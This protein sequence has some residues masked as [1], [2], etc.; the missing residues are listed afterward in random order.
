M[1]NRKGRRLLGLSLL[2][3]A[4]ACATLTPGGASTSAALA[5]GMR[6]RAWVGTPSRL[7]WR[8]GWLLALTADSLVMERTDILGRPRLALP[9]DSIRRLE[10]H[11]GGRDRASASGCLIGGVVVA[12][13]GIVGES[14]PSE[15]RLGA[16]FVL[17]GAGFGC[18]IGILVGAFVG[19]GGEWE[20]LSVLRGG[21]PP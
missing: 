12:V 18:A 8:V 20:T 19:D 16:R 7:D 9:V 4:T 11:R 17:A 14:T 21:S 5:P 3:A 13:L 6:V 15:G 1:P 2:G 10:V